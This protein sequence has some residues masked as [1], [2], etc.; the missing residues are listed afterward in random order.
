MPRRL[1]I[2]GALLYVV[3]AWGLNMIISKQIIDLI[4]PLAFTSLRFVAMTPL[5]FLLVRLSGVRIHVERRDIPALVLCGLCGYGAYQFF[6]I[7]GLKHTTPFASALLFSTAP[8]F[9]L[10]IV[11]IAGHE[12]VRPSRWAGAAV[13]LLGVAIFEG[14]FSGQLFFR[15]GDTLALSSAII[16]AGYNVLG[17]RLLARYSALELLAITMTVGAVIV[18][19]AGIPALLH[20]DFSALRWGFWWRFAYA[21]LFPIVLTYPVWNWGLREVGAGKGSVMQF[22]VPVLTG[23]LSVPLI[24]AR[25]APYELIGAV[26]C[27]GGMTF[28]ITLGGRGTRAATAS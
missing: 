7:F 13:A 10:M 17:A 8:I 19:P 26:V 28:A 9:T 23:I 22:L 2:Y 12:H 20:T 1:L 5:A 15:L 4:S 18:C 21:A 3:L 6:W 14:L 11:A 24:N 27:L 16:F 25:F